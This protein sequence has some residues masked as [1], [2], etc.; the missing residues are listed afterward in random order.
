MENLSRH[1]SRLCF[2]ALL[3]ASQSSWSVR[4]R[5]EIE[6]FLFYGWAFPFLIFSFCF[7]C[8]LFYMGAQPQNNVI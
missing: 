5:E 8:G 7:Y 2:L 4:G 1:M 3:W 6:R